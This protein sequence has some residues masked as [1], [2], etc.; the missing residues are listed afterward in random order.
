MEHLIGSYKQGFELNWREEKVTKKQH[1][2]LTLLIR[3]HFDEI[4]WRRHN[5]NSISSLLKC[6]WSDIHRVHLLDDLHQTNCVSIV[7]Y[8][9]AH[10]LAHV[11]FLMRIGIRA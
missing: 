5:Y 3:S 1:R 8:Y 4:P 2:R 7:F 9:R 10:E 11:S 6:F